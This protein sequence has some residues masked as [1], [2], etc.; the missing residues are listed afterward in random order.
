MII[1]VSSGKGQLRGVAVLPYRKWPYNVIPY[2]ISPVTG[3]IIIL[4][5]NFFNNLIE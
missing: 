3:Q 4:Y 5:E 2:E 1:P